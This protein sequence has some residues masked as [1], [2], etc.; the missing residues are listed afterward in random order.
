MCLDGQYLLGPSLLP[1]LLVLLSWWPVKCVEDGH[2]RLAIKLSR[3]MRLSHPKN[4]AYVRRWPELFWCAFLPL[5]LV[6]VAGLALN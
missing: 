6:V 4:G 3:S 5:S 1:L 2:H